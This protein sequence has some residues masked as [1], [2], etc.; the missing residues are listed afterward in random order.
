MSEDIEGTE[1]LD[2]SGIDR[3]LDR[4]PMLPLLSL[5][6]WISWRF[7]AFSGTMSIG[8]GKQDMLFYL[9]LLI[10]CIG[11]VTLPRL[12]KRTLTIPVTVLGALA[13][14]GTLCLLFAG[15]QGP[16]ASSM[17]IQAISL[18][19]AALTGLG[20]GCIAIKSCMLLGRL[21]P[22]EIWIWL[23]YTE[24]V[25][26]SIYFVVLGTAGPLASFLFAA[27]PLLAGVTASLGD[28]AA[29]HW[30][31]RIET[32]TDEAAVPRSTYL[33]FALFV[34]LLSITCYLARLVSTQG[35]ID[36]F[37]TNM[38]AW[39]ALGRILLALAILGG[40][41]F[42]SR[43]FPF[44]RMCVFV[45][46]MILAVLACMSLPGF[47]SFWLFTLTAFA[48]PVLECLT[49]AIAACLMYRTPERSL[50]IGALALGALYGVVPIAEGIGWAIEAVAPEALS[51]V[52][53]IVVVLSAADALLFLQDKTYDS[54]MGSIERPREQV[55][56]GK[57]RRLQQ[58]QSIKE[59]MNL[60]QREYDVLLEIQ[61]GQSAQKIAEHMNLSVHT[62]R[63]HIQSIYNKCGVHSRDELVDLMSTIE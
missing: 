16:L 12:T 15:P 20:I 3:I 31:A 62:V 9:T 56:R 11:A 48:H 33:K 36:P 43:R 52:F 58:A 51:T 7:I 4:W 25:V 24:F 23:A 55:S 17:M 27:L 6:F 5:A 22:T 50:F 60:S 47:D 19:G 53:L 38:L 46:V 40:V 63:G 45:M 1:S 34:A 37:S 35:I 32:A 44:S 41:V 30:P 54:V 28:R 21:R 10:G 26:V 14:L 57:Q 29:Q 59:R 2:Q 61:R 39:P 13:S 49:L 18:A 8:L 42:F